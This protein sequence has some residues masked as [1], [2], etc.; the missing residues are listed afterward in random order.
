M[1]RQGSSLLI[2]LRISV[3]FAMYYI[4]GRGDEKGKV[5]PEVYI[6]WFSEDYIHE[7]CTLNLA[8]R[9][10]VAWRGS[11]MVSPESFPHGVLF[12]SFFFLGF[13]T[14]FHNVNMTF[15]S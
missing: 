14:P 15:L 3:G 9:L 4:G 11:K 7:T 10:M 1:R 6:T 8:R 2:E 13:D 12:L 5:F